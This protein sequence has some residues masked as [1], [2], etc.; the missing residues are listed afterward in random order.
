M[1]H[2]IETQHSN[3]NETPVQHIKLHVVMLNVAIK[4]SVVRVSV[5]APLKACDLRLSIKTGKHMNMLK[6][7]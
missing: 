7:M 3:K 5:M 2:Y 1:A 4:Q 6:E